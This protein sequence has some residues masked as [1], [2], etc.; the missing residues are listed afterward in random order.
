[1]VRVQIRDHL[2]TDVERD[3]LALD[4]FLQGPAHGAYDSQV[5]VISVYLCMVVHSVTRTRTPTPVS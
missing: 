2:K 4:M 5:H 3:D 1:M